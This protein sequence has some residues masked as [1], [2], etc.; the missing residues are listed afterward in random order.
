MKTKKLFLFGVLILAVLSLQR[1]N[2]AS[3]RFLSDAWGAG[4]G[5][6][7]Q[8]A[9]C[10][11]DLGTGG[12]CNPQQDCEGTCRST[13]PLG[14]YDFLCVT[15]EGECTVSMTTCSDISKYKCIQVAGGGCQCVYN[16]YGGFCSRQTC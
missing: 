16:G 8:G 5:T 4:C 12:D 15:S 14:D 1:I 11:S 13:C 7:T 2:N 9:R 6:C 3:E 10:G